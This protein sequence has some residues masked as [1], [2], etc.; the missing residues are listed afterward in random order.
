MVTMGLL[1]LKAISAAGYYALMA[2]SSGPQIRGGESAVM[3]R[4][5]TRPVGCQDDRFQLLLALDWFNFSRFADEIPLTSQTLVLHDPAMGDVPPV[6]IE[7]AAQLHEISLKALAKT[8][9][10]GRPNMLALGLLAALLG[11]DKCATE[12][13]FYVV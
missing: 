2:R 4:V 12:R 13:A 9:E 11:I 8:I 7:S 10:G 3:L 1:F 5:G 6:V